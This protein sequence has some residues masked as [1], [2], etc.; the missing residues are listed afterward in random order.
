M[1]LRKSTGR[2][3]LLHITYSG[4]HVDNVCNCDMRVCMRFPAPN[5]PPTNLVVFNETTNSLNARWNPAPGRVQI[6]KITYVPTSGGRSQSVSHTT[7]R[8]PY[9]VSSYCSHFFLIYTVQYF[10]F[11]EAEVISLVLLKNNLYKLVIS[12]AQVKKVTAYILSSV[13]GI[14]IG[15]KD[16]TYS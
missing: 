7:D 5:A 10:I 13:R 11:H 14:A 9:T 12:N 8:H 6:Y 2:V 15:W 1:F 16:N 4:Q 3:L